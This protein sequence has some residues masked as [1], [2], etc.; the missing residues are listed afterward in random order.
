MTIPLWLKGTLLLGMTAAGG[1][2]IGMGMERR[3]A[4]AP[5]DAHL[6]V[7]ATSPASL[8]LRH[9]ET[10]VRLD[11]AQR[12]EISSILARHQAGIDSAWRHLQPNIKA[13]LDSSLRE[14]AAVL[15]AQQ[16]ETFRRMVARHHPGVLP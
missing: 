5:S 2:L 7:V 16:R 10:E 8:L 6:V 13:T 4:R 3:R 11:S 15:D 12:R 1:C 9:L 14:I